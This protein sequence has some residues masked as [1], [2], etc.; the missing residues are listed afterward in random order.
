MCVG[1]R[2]AGNANILN[3]YSSSRYTTM[4]S[5]VCEKANREC[6]SG[7]K[8]KDQNLVYFKLPA[9]VTVPR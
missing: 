6:G 2:D 7:G 3:I 5:R 9:L 4:S 8:E 1:I